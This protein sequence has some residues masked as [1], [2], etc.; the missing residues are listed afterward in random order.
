MT[1]CEDA[2]RLCNLMVTGQLPLPGDVDASGNT[3]LEEDTA[4]EVISPLS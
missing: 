4:E 1:H 3:F 2:V